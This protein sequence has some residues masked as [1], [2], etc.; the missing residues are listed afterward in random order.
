[1]LRFAFVEYA[2]LQEAER[3]LR[4]TN[5]M[6]FD[7]RHTLVVN[8]YEDLARFS[9][10]PSEFQNPIKSPWAPDDDLWS[11]LGDAAMRDQL[12]MRFAE[13]GTRDKMHRTEVSFLSADG[14]LTMVCDDESGQVKRGGSWTEQG[15]QWSPKGTYLATMHPQGVL[16]WGGSSFQEI[17]RFAHPAVESVAFSPCERWC[18][19][20][21]GMRDNET[22]DRALIV[23]DMRTGTE[24][25]AFK[26]VSLATDSNDAVWSHSG[27]FLARLDV[28]YTTGDDLV[29]VYVPPG[30]GLLE[31]RSIIAPGAQGL[32][33]APG[34]PS[35]ILSWFVPEKG[36]LPAT[37]TVMAMP[38]RDVLR[39]KQL[40]NVER[41]QTMW[42]PQGRYFAVQS[43][44]LTKAQAKD[45]KRFIAND[46]SAKLKMLME[47][48]DGDPHGTSFE[49]FR[50]QDRSVPTNT[51]QISGKV[52]D[53]SFEPQ[54][55]RFAIVHG[56]GPSTYDVS[57]YTLSSS[58]PSAAAAAAD[59]GADI[60]WLFTLKSRQCTNVIW[61]PNGNVCVL[62]GLGMGPLEFFDANT[63]ETYAK[64]DHMQCSAV[65]WDPSGRTVVSSKAQPVTPHD[66]P[67]LMVENGYKV[68]TWQGKQLLEEGLPFLYDVQWRPRPTIL[69]AAELAEVKAALP[70][71]I[72]QFEA[73]DKAIRERRSLVKRAR[74]LRA[75]Q[76]YRELMAERKA[77]MQQLEA[78]RQA[79]GLV[80]AGDD[81]QITSHTY[82]QIVKQVVERV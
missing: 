72:A 40:F 21:N 38:S 4:S 11:W 37:V 2:S 53:F 1:L 45:R 26:Q 8:R 59:T 58:T 78:T 29:R 19:T 10:I 6:Q 9:D 48:I 79:R 28:D 50:V 15:L 14:E 46:N 51:L 32:S 35:D 68:W 33:F 67:K 44:M 41:I 43:C 69:D 75:L 63:R 62:A 36:D 39:A 25:R 74:K 61:S 27:T 24:L 16:L 73:E 54:G 47:R 20:W 30:M 18:M 56:R 64:Q 22:P 77:W 13:G 42:H 80:L 76:Q 60:E 57:F 3:A 49:L 71:R 66:E 81:V 31:K 34:G 52:V 12:V 17:F 5:N 55:D 23:W 7:A 82:D 70:G 65:Q